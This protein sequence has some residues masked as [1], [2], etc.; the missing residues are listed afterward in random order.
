MNKTWIRFLPTFI[1]KSIDGRHELQKV[2]SNTGWLFFDNFLRIGVGFFVNA[3]I[4]RYLGPERFGLLSYALAFVA[5]FAP[6]AQLGLDA[7]VVRNIIH[8]PN[9]R[10]EIVGS[11]FALKLC[12]AGSAII[13]AL[14]SIVIVRPEDRLTQALVGICILGT[15]LQSFGVID[16]WFQAQVSSKFSV[17]AKSSA[18]LTGYII[19]IILI[20]QGGSLLSF[21]YAGLAELFLGSAGLILAYHF[22]GM[23]ITSWQPSRE[24]ALRLLRDSWMFMIADVVYFVYLRVDRIMI[25]EISGPAELGIYSVAVMVAEAFFFIPASVSLSIFPEILKAQTD[26]PELFKKRIQQFYSLMVFLGYLVAI[27]LSLVAGWLIPFV[28]GP[29]YNGTVNMLL[30]LV[31][32]GVFLNMLHARSYFLTAMNWPRLHLGIDLVGC[33]I[34]ISLNLYLI[35]RNG[36]IGAAVA[37]LITYFFTAYLICFAFKPLRETGLMMT[38]AMLFPKFW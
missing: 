8:Y 4:I 37:S 12:G 5:L 36:G 27:P 16:F 22:T 23:P 10:D 30:I 18:C 28:F 14:I 33:L 19:K 20:W 21:A 6:L 3:W 34:N 13:L 29:A 15:L 9:Q 35:P 31:W 7:V 17:I 1:R 32:A 38:R 11:A 25:G 2:M 26:S 24:M